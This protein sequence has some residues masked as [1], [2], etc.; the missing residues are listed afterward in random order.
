MMRNDL[1]QDLA[2][3]PLLKTWPVRGAAL[4]RGEVLA[5]TA[6][7]TAVAWLLLLTAALLGGGLKAGSGEAN[8]FQAHRVSYLTA[9]MV[10]APAI[11]L[12]QVVVQ[13]GLAVLFP[14]W[15]AVGTSRARGIDAM[16][17]RLLMLAG[18]LLTLVVSLLPGVIA[19]GALAFLVYQFTG[20]TLVLLPALV[21][22]LVIAGE[23]WL[24]IEGLG[25]ILERTDPS[26]VETVE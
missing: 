21:V 5:P 23:C 6:I 1:R 26:A 25:R 20:A 10:L 24:A 12:A 2:R 14:A 16:G 19:A 3:L 18:I 13:N 8:A 7:V 4:I 11:V 17:Q 22:V 9:A 15:V